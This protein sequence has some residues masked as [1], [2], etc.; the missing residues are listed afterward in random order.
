MR[1]QPLA[2]IILLSLPAFAQRELPVDT[3]QVNQLIALSLKD[4]W[5]DPYRS[6]SY[7]DQALEQ[8]RQIDYRKGIARALNLIGFSNW[9]FGDNELAIQSALEAVDIARQEKYPLIQAD[10][11]YIMARGYMDLRENS[12]AH[13][14]ITTAEKLAKE[15]ND[16]TQLCSIYNLKGVIL[17][18]ANK[19][20]SALYFYN[21]AYEIGKNQAV[22][23]INLPRIISNIGECYQRD[24]PALAFRYFTDAL[25]LAKK[26]G[27]HHRRSF[28]HKHH[29]SRLL[30]REGF[31]K[32][33]S[34]FTDRTQ[35][36]E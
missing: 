27:Q 7:A 3:T 14:S 36:C 17:Y 20:D 31:E 1:W 32:C 9:T 18:S 19:Y 12:K 6:L 22:D 34:Q 13:E 24:N 35:A 2:F 33:R 11:Y 28:H 21:K 10:S 23:P 16:W 29:R 5:V 26:D 4:Q 30:A 25:D 15:G 8:A